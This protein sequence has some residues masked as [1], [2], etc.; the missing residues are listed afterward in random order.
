MNDHRDEIENAA[1][2]Y[3]LDPDLVEGLV[4]VESGGDQTA[5]NPEGQ[6]RYF[7]NVATG[8]PF[9][10]VTEKEISN[11][12]PP[13]DFPCLKGDPDQEWWGQQAS[14][15]LMQ[16]MGAVA[17]ERGYKAPYLGGLLNDVDAALDV[18]CKHLGLLLKLVRGDVARALAVYNGGMRGNEKR[19]LRNQ[20]YA[21]RVMAARI[22]VIHRRGA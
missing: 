6:Y 13:D 12:Y 8:K 3:E 18:G 11:E 4:Q 21:D 5:W 17:R 15:G 20:K 14:W 9:R 10:K 19:P 1:K 22:V 2:L 7:W 16:V